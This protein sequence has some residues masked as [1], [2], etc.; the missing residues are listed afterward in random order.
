M[1]LLKTST[2]V[3]ILLHLQDLLGLLI[4]LVLDGPGIPVLKEGEELCHAYGLLTNVTKTDL[5][6][7]S[8]HPLLCQQW[9]TPS[10]HH[11]L[12]Q[13]GHSQHLSTVCCCFT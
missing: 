11:L 8:H 3:I 10:P 7:Q 5:P 2:G 6:V 12:L 9:P 13:P 4:L 1:L